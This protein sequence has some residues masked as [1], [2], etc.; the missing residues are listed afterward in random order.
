[1]SACALSDKILLLDMGRDLNYLPHD[2]MLKASPLYKELYNAW[3][4]YFMN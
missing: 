2:E 1:M 4:K 3:A